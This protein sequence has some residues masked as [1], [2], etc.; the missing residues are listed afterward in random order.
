M[1]NSKVYALL[2][3]E[4]SSSYEQIKGFEPKQECSAS[5]MCTYTAQ[6]SHITSNL[7]VSLEWAVLDLCNLISSFDLRCEMLHYTDNISVCS[8]VDTCTR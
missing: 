8:E 4:P 5:L 1:H 7:V 2:H 3:K 6:L